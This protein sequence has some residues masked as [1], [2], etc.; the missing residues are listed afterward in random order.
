M[1]PRQLGE[2]RLARILEREM[3]E[4]EPTGLLPDATPEGLAPHRHWLEP[5]A[6]DPATGKLV[7]PV[8]S[9]LVRTRRHN[10]LIDACLGEQ[11]TDRF[12][13]PWNKLSGSRFLGDLAALGL[14]PEDVHFVLCTHLHS[15]HVGWNTRRRDGRWVPTF[16]KA[17]Y[18][19]SRREVEH[20]RERQ[21]EDPQA[22]GADS[23]E[24]SVLPVIEAR[25]AELVAEDHALDDEV[26]LEPLPGH[27]AGHFGVRLASGGA[28]AIMIGDLMHSPV[29]C[30][31]PDWTA[32]SDLDPALAR[33]TRR[34]FLETHAET[35]C[36][37]L[38]A[39]FPSPSVGHIRRAGNAFRFAYAD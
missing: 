22:D 9:Y 34:R 11:K 17:R 16:P 15:D 21:R 5:K 28:R 12:Y 27:T 32:S 10:I 3:P 38:T 14:A 35:D 7:L 4:F 6:V 29:Q 31:E 8:Q 37:V 13:A 19:M 26:W 30:A 25:Q 23:L 39:H 36:L 20:A 24:E 2:I 18:V 33:A 1:K